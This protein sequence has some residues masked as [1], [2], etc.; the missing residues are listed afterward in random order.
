MEYRQGPERL[1]RY[2]CHAAWTIIIPWPAEVW[3]NEGRKQHTP[4]KIDFN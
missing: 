2:G 4:L 1:G 3:N